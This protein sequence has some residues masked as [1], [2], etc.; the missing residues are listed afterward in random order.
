MCETLKKSKNSVL[1]CSLRV[2]YSVKPV[3]ILQVNMAF[4]QL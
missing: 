2:V 4:Q 1:F 3:A